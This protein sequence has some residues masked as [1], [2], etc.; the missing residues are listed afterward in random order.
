M[1]IVRRRSRQALVTERFGSS[2]EWPAVRAFDR[3]AEE[4]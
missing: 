1:P 3:R 2:D 4:G